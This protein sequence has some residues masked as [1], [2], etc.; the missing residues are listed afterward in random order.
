MRPPLVRPS[1]SML[2]GVSTALASHL[3]WP[4]RSVRLIFVVATLVMGA[5]ALLYAWL[6]ALTPLEQDGEDGVRVHRSVPTSALLLA[7]GF[8]AAVVA[9]VLANTANDPYLPIV[10]AIALTGSAVAFSLTL[11]RQDSGRTA[12]YT[13][14]V[15]TSSVLL[16]V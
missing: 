13:F 1:R 11:D 3:G 12:K 10:L 8:V 2:G 15:R 4:V 5:G 7:A 6:W 9:V 16:L 14:V